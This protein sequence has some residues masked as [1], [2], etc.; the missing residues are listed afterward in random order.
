MVVVTE[1]TIEKAEER[2]VIGHYTDTMG[3]HRVIEAPPMEAET[4][5]PEFDDR[6][7]EDAVLAFGTTDNPLE[8]GY[9]LRDG[10]L[11]DFS[12]GVRNEVTIGHP[13]ISQ[14]VRSGRMTEAWLA[15]P[16]FCQKTGAIRFGLYLREMT[17][18][19]LLDTYSMPTTAQ[20]RHIAQAID[21]LAK[22][23]RAPELAITLCLPTD[24]LGHPSVSHRFSPVT[25]RT[26]GQVRRLAQ[27]LY[28]GGDGEPVV[29][30][31]GQRTAVGF[32]TDPSGRPRPITLPEPHAVAEATKDVLEYTRL[33][34]RA[35]AFKAWFGDWDTDPASASKVVHEQTGEPVENYPMSHVTGPEGQPQVVYHGS[36]TGA[37]REFDKDKQTGMALYG[38]GFYFT[39]DKDMAGSYQEKGAIV[40]DDLDALSAA[41]REVMAQAIREDMEPRFLSSGEREYADR[42]LNYW[43]EGKFSGQ[44]ILDMFSGQPFLINLVEPEW[45]RQKAGLVAPTKDP[46]VF[47]CYLNMRDPIRFD[48]PVTAE[49]KQRLLKGFE[50]T[51]VRLDTYG[52]E[53][54]DSLEDAIDGVLQGEDPLHQATK[55][56]EE[57]GPA[58]TVAAMLER[59]S[60]YLS[61][62]DPGEAERGFTS[63][64]YFF[65]REQYQEVLQA[66]GYDGITHIG[67]TMRGTG[68]HLHRV[69]I[70][71]EPTQV[72]AVENVGTFDPDYCDIY[73][74]DTGQMTLGFYTD[75]GGRTRPI[76]KPKGKPL[77]P[78]G[79]SPKARIGTLG[80]N[81]RMA[82]GRRKVQPE[83]VAHL[84]EMLGHMADLHTLSGK[85]P[86]SGG[87]LSIV[88]R[89]PN[90]MWSRHAGARYIREDVLI[91]LRGD[92]LE[93]LQSLP[94]ELWH[95][96]QNEQLYPPFDDDQA[97]AWTALMAV[98]RKRPE[99]VLLVLLHSLKAMRYHNKPNEQLARLYSQ[100]VT[101]KLMEK[102]VEL[103]P[104][105]F[106]QSEPELDDRGWIWAAGSSEL[107]SGRAALNRIDEAWEA[108]YE[109]HC[110]R[111]A[112][113][114]PE[115]AQANLL[116]YVGRPDFERRIQWAV[117]A[118]WG[119]PVLGITTARTI[120][121]T[122]EVALS[123][124]Q[125]KMLRATFEERDPDLFAQTDALME[126]G[127]FW[128]LD[129]S[130][131]SRELLYPLLEEFLEAG[132][133][134]VKKL[135]AGWGAMGKA[136]EELP[137]GWYTDPRR[138]VRP[139]MRPR[140]PEAAPPELAETAPGRWADRV[141][142]VFASMETQPSEWKPVAVKG[143]AQA[144]DDRGE[145][146]TMPEFDFPK[147]YDKAPSPLANVSGGG[148]QCEVCAHPLRFAYWLQH[149][150][151]KWLLLVGSECVNN[152]VAAALP[153][154]E[155]EQVRQQIKAT[156]KKLTVEESETA[157]E[158][159]AAGVDVGAATGAAK[160]ASAA[161]RRFDKKHPAP[162]E[163][164]EETWQG[165]RARYESVRR[166]K[167]SGSYLSEEDYYLWREGPLGAFEDAATRKELAYAERTDETLG[168]AWERERGGYIEAAM[169]KAS[170][171]VRAYLAAKSGKMLA[172]VDRNAERELEHMRE[173]DAEAELLPGYIVS[174]WT[175]TDRATK[176][177]TDIG[178]LARPMRVHVNWETGKY[179]TGGSPQ[180]RPTNWHQ[181]W[182]EERPETDAE[183]MR[184]LVDALRRQDHYV[185]ELEHYEHKD[186]TAPDRYVAE[187]GAAQAEKSEKLAKAD[188]PR[189]IG[190]YTTWSGERRPITD[191][192]PYTPELPPHLEG[193]RTITS[194]RIDEFTEEGSYEGQVFWHATNQLSSVMRHGLLSD[195]ERSAVLGSRFLTTRHPQGLGGG[196]WNT[197]SVTSEREVAESIVET[198]KHAHDIT[199]APS[200]WRAAEALASTFGPTQETYALT[201][202]YSEH[203]IGRDE[204]I[205]RARQGFKREQFSLW[206]KR[207]APTVAEAEA[208]GWEVTAARPSPDDP[209][210]KVLGGWR[211][212][213]ED[214]KAKSALD[215][216]RCFRRALEHEEGILDPLLYSPDVDALRAL[217]PLDTGVVAVVTRA[218]EVARET[219][220]LGEYVFNPEDCAVVLDMAEAKPWWQR[221]QRMGKFLPSERRVVGW[222]T[223]REGRRRPIVLAD[224]YGRGVEREREE[225][226]AE[227]WWP[228]IGEPSTATTGPL[229]EDN[230][231]YRITGQLQAWARAQTFGAVTT[232][233]GTR[234]LPQ[235]G[236]APSYHWRQDFVPE[237][238]AS[239]LTELRE[240]RWVSQG[241]LDRYLSAME[242]VPPS[243]SEATQPMLEVLGWPKWEDSPKLRLAL[244][245]SKSQHRFFDEVVLGWWRYPTFWRA[246]RLVPIYAIGLACLGEGRDRI[247]VHEL[248]SKQIMPIEPD[249]WGRDNPE[250]VLKGIGHCIEATGIPMH[251]E[252]DDI[253]FDEPLEDWL[254]LGLRDD[255]KLPPAGAWWMLD[256]E[257]IEQWRQLPAYEGQVPQEEQHPGYTVFAWA[258]SGV[259]DEDARSIVDEQLGAIRAVHRLPTV[260]AMRNLTVQVDERPLVQCR[261]EYKHEHNV[262]HI[263]DDDRE[264]FAH[265]FM[266]AMDYVLLGRA[267]KEKDKKRIPTSATRAVAAPPEKQQREKDVFPEYQDAVGALAE[268]FR[269]RLPRDPLEPETSRW[270]DSVYLRDPAEQ[271]ARAYEQWLFYRALEEGSEAARLVVPNDYGGGARYWT[272]EE[273]EELR[274]QMDA[275]IDAIPE[276]D[277]AKAA[278]AIADTTGGM[279]MPTTEARV[280]G[281]HEGGDIIQD[282]DEWWT[283]WPDGTV[284]GYYGDTI[285]LQEA[286]AGGEEHT[287]AVVAQPAG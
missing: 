138:Q 181:E 167:A 10:R 134:D 107:V 133:I 259:T 223:D 266:H 215:W 29:I 199:T 109:E 62:P 102:G 145:T 206:P 72:K 76:T 219:A 86:K 4:A 274:P 197:V 157:N 186:A 275:L 49:V 179:R 125:W 33:G 192:R 121:E 210:A 164:L 172:T 203:W 251:M 58:A 122:I 153:P 23:P 93:H 17:P 140:P 239:A 37:F 166:A 155:A 15:V 28:E 163:E 60:K 139:I 30:K 90:I 95:F 27:R 177:E 114:T 168:V 250:H 200:P 47:A 56:G 176:K 257:H 123:N 44:A 18:H 159:M 80:I 113:D 198:L 61:K 152:Y 67:G 111:P 64:E 142:W 282:G 183:Y 284:R 85:A 270:M 242:D 227:T 144:E 205:Q 78:A 120:R 83:E 248:M 63:W 110:Q 136:Q 234:A 42:D 169:G 255:A 202:H 71:F 46:H 252:G 189:I 32:Y 262:I 212:M 193:E 130:P 190:W 11:L 231:A 74:R 158:L 79:P 51:Q 131:E 88:V 191:P 65:G 269:G 208:A 160:K 187:Y 57:P 230:V 39:E 276:K 195:D 220:S 285:A 287:E 24:D 35:R 237:R 249:L 281:T 232:P 180:L 173:Y 82:S 20:W 149:D 55:A 81:L 182:G 112:P 174:Y 124:E 268:A 165:A 265:E 52:Q 272:A 185:G 5:Q 267:T 211:P 216:Y 148:M 68:E 246:A 156:K 34:V 277:L 217:D 254:Y 235:A 162:T 50:A 244:E 229:D 96:M 105:L 91:E 40:G 286:L 22:G 253:V 143:F 89:D 243:V 38:A 224:V 170:P 119:A 117:T 201:D 75:E 128:A 233:E 283:L 31:A 241:E 3:R 2:R 184:E 256:E 194:D 171:A 14:V 1:R 271:L 146:V 214:E 73:K 16:E 70:A 278:V 264:S 77:P 279:L 132:G 161:G 101:D 236:P 221:D 178:Y 188:E 258:K 7:E 260:A 41:D 273:F 106:P 261:A 247:S 21:S 25:D 129:F 196:Q 54:F 209:E 103:P 207:D 118:K 218:K 135:L 26:S 98:L 84:A 245:L 53:H 127:Q 175:R 226:W 141:G 280:V 36:V 100:W 87:N 69:W 116:A 151:K 222:Y 94:H 43:L 137:I 8:A 263:S 204:A 48:E 238:I 13:D 19:M 115:E 59:M 104:G 99:R 228:R 66:A 9:I 150:E 6:M 108:W 154:E 45:W 126:K 12:G 147:G 240:L 213:T 97:H 225:A 92:A